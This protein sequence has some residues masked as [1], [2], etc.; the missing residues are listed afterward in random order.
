[1]QRGWAHDL[2]ARPRLGMFYTLLNGSESQPGITPM[3][4]IT[5][6]DRKIPCEHAMVLD[7]RT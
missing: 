7:L 5:A 4:A 2:R 3:Y 1:M 6:L